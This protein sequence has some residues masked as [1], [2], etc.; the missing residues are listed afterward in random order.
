MNTALHMCCLGGNAEA[1]KAILRQQKVDL[2][3]T[4]ID[5]FTPLVPSMPLPNSDPRP[6]PQSS[7][8]L[9]Q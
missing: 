1:V 7:R 2:E 6:H 3:K 4:N 5:N 9:V 8:A